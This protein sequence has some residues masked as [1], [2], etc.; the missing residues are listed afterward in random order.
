MV[1][2]G[3]GQIT[4]HQ[5]HTHTHVMHQQINHV[6]CNRLNR[7]HC[8]VLR[9]A[10]ASL[11]HTKCYVD[12]I[13][14]IAT[15]SIHLL[16]SSCPTS[17]G[18]HYIIKHLFLNILTSLLTP[19]EDLYWH[20]QTS[21]LKHLYIFAYIKGDL[22]SHHETSFSKHLYTFTYIKRGSSL[23]TSNFFS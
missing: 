13:E 21:F 18:D 3:C 7:E 16:G 14:S 10:H 19:K 20:L 5:A 8:N 22:Y 2:T 6:Q 15:E 4:I 17:A 1:P 11:T 9:Q 23:W 12:S